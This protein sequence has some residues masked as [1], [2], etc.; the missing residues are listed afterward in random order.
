MW[1]VVFSYQTV[2]VKKK[3]FPIKLEILHVLIVFWP[4]NY[5]LTD[6]LYICI[7]NVVTVF[8]YKLDC[9]LISQKKWRPL[10]KIDRGHLPAS[11]AGLWWAPIDSCV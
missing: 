9:R 1:F 4:S 6:E 5:N 7:R 11:A 8:G 3:G 2:F 10:L